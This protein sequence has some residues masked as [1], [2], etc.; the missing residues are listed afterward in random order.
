MGIN[1]NTN[2]TDL[3][4]AAGK[5]PGELSGADTAKISAD[6]N[7]IGEKKPTTTEF[8]GKTYT[9]EIWV[10]THVNGQV[11]VKVSWQ[12]GDS[13]YYDATWITP[14]QGKQNA[15][16]NKNASTSLSPEANNVLEVQAKAKLPNT[17]R[18]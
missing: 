13:S 11:E 18:I 4:V 10:N 14:G 6:T 17:K 5:K 8:N 9:A 2:K 16:K 7:I 3:N 15:N 1:F 12:D